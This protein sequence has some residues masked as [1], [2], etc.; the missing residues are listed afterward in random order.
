MNFLMNNHKDFLA[1]Q[2]PVSFSWDRRGSPKMS[3]DSRDRRGRSKKIKKCNFYVN[4]MT[5]S[6]LFISFR[7]WEKN[8][9]VMKLDE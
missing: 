6:E 3:F 5:N 4:I 2:D 9:R 8:L 1:F 7:V